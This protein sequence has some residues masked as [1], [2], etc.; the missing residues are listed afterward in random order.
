[1]RSTRELALWLFIDF[2]L[3]Q[4]S[5]LWLHNAWYAHRGV[6]TAVDSALAVFWAH[7]FWKDIVRWT[8]PKRRVK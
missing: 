4:L 2:T 1:M 5:V 7:E 3:M 6:S 8:G